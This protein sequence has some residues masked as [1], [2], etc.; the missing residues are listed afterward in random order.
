MIIKEAEISKG[1]LFQYFNNKKELYL[2]LLDYVI[3]ITDMIYTEIDLNET[4]YFNR[5]KEIGLIKFRIMKKFPQA[6]DFL[7]N[8]LDEDNKDVKQEIKKVQKQA[9]ENGFEKGYQNIDW[10]KFREDMDL[11]KMKNIIKWTF[12][13]FSGQQV[14]KINSFE[15]VGKEV[16]EEWED[17]F[18]ILKRCFYKKE[19]I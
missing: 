12:L 1:S 8:V 15:N 18:D 10:T 19:D 11:N 7:K 14:R 3:K 6:F 17:Y 13:N 2:F 16:L 9:L 5:T 4:D